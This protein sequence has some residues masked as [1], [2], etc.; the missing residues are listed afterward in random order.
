MIHFYPLDFIK[1][2]KGRIFNFPV[3]INNGNIAFL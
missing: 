2:T 3:A 1:L